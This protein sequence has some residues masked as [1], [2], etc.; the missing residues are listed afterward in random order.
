MS[1]LVFGIGKTI[2]GFI[3]FVLGIAFGGTV[4]SIMF[5]ILDSVAF[6]CM[7]CAHV[8]VE[9]IGNGRGQ[10]V[11]PLWSRF[12]GY[13]VA[14]TLAALFLICSALTHYFPHGFKRRKRKQ[15]RQ[16]SG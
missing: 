16:R 3:L 6:N 14:A 7:E 11:D 12:L 1:R 8:I 2:L 15:Q 5:I 10:W 4:L 9:P 13:E